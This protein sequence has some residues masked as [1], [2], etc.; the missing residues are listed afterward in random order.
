[1]ATRTLSHRALR[2]QHDQALKNEQKKTDTNNSSE[3]EVKAKKPRVRKIAAS[4]VAGEKLPA[5]PRARKKAAKVPPRMF[6]RW[7]VCDGGLKRLAFFEYK[8]RSG[9]DARLIQLQEQKK[10]PFF[11]LLVKEPYDPPAAESVPAV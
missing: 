10:G 5:K 2:V 4:K 6:A 7:A 1:M 8:D 3:T 11:I 9:A